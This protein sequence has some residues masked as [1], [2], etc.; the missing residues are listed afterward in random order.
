MRKTI[1]ILVILDVLALG[2]F[3][4]TYGPW[5]YCRNFW[6]TTSMTSM[7][8]H[9]LAK[10]FYSDE[11]I[12]EVLSQNYVKSV[13]EDTNVEL[14]IIGNINKPTSYDSVYEKQILEHDEDDVYKLIEFTY[15]GYNCYLAAIYDPTRVQLASTAYL[16]S[17]GQLITEISSA[18]N[19]LVAVNAG[20]FNDPN[21]NGNGGTPGGL[22]I[23]DGKI[24]WGNYDTT[25]TVA[26]FNDKGVLILGNM[27]GREA[28]ERKVQYSVSFSPF[29][30]VN[31]K[32]SEI[33]GNG[34]WGINPRTAI[35][36]RQDGIVLFLVV[37]GNGSSDWLTWNGRGGIAMSD[38]ITILQRY[39]AYNAVNMDG[40]AST[41]ITF[42]SKVYNNPCSGGRS[43]G[44]RYIPNAWIVK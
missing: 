3:F 8:H 21:G 2:G 7:N 9:Y 31:G 5:D 36:Q 33:S 23:E 30:I 6:I 41:A 38:L 43:D 22:V 1:V 37:D 29:L 12:S 15:N 11:T 4:I 32:A 19:A 34:G 26:G 40:G 13:D 10:V 18:N 25:Y 39:N 35:A 44:L 14:I 42:N 27:T 24:V 16:G 28:L 17:Y 20:G